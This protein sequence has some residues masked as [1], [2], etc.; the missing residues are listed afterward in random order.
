MQTPPLRVE[1]T[2]IINSLGTQAE[3]DEPFCGLP[4]SL[5]TALQSCTLLQKR[6]LKLPVLS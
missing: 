6:L 3:T 2:Q 5:H 4:M 1:Q